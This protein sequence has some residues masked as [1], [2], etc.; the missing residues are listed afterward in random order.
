MNSDELPVF[1]IAKIQEGKI[2]YLEKLM[3][4]DRATPDFPYPILNRHKPMLVL[5]AGQ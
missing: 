1:Q 4:Q 2:T 3:E 5:A